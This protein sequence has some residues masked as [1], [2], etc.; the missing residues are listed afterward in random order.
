MMRREKRR[1]RY[2]KRRREERREWYDET[3]VKESNH[4]LHPIFVGILLVR[5]VRTYASYP[6]ILGYFRL[7][8]ILQRLFRVCHE[9]GKWWMR[10]IRVYQE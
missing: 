4:L 2:D 7:I 8:C 1:E 10:G 6:S 5:V 3:S 9:E